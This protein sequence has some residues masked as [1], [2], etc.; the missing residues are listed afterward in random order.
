[1]KDVRW[2]VYFN[3]WRLAYGVER[4][5]LTDTG[6]QDPSTAQTI[7]KL[8][9]G[10]I[11]EISIKLNNLKLRSLKSI[12]DEEFK[13]LGNLANRIISKTLN[14]LSKISLTGHCLKNFLQNF[15]L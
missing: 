8:T 12:H 11:S 15:N 7:G 3:T 4:R 6:F 5:R 14:G 9:D 10:Q 2:L 13:E 1:M